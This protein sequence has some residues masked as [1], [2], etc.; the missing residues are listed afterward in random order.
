MPLVLVF[1][2]TSACPGELIRRNGAGGQRPGSF[3]IGVSGKSESPTP[4]SGAGLFCHLRWEEDELL[5][6]LLVFGYIS[7]VLPYT[8]TAT[9][10]FKLSQNGTYYSHRLVSVQI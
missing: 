4:G 8:Y 2:S 3:E 10:S 1:V 5:I 7:E 9:L 6:S